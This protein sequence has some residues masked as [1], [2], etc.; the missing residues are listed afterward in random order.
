MLLFPFKRRTPFSALSPGLSLTLTLAS[1]TLASGTLALG[2]LPG[3]GGSDPTP[4]PSSEVTSTPETPTSVP[5][6][7]V[8]TAAPTPTEVPTATPI[9]YTPPEVADGYDFWIG[10]LG[11][12][13]PLFSGEQQYPF[14]CTTIESNLGQP[15]IDNVNGIGNAVFPEVNGVPDMEGT[16][17]GYSANCSLRTRVDYY[18]FSSTDSRFHAYDENNP[19]PDLATL[20]VK[21]KTE[22]FLVRVETGTLDRFIYTIAMLAP[23]AEV[24]TSPD[25]LDNSAWN[26]KLLY[27]FRGG[28]GIGHYQGFA[29]WAGGLSDDE[30][31]AFSQSLAKGYA[32]AT[33]TGN[34]TGVHYNMELAHEA[35]L[36]VKKHFVATYGAPL[37]TV[38]AGGS[39]GGVQQYLIGQNQDDGDDKVLDGGL[40]LY[41]YPDMV[42]QTIPV[43]DC[44]L[45]EQYFLE[46]MSRNPINSKWA[47]WSNRAWIEG[48]NASDTVDNSVFDTMGS[49]ECIEAWFF[50]EPLA[51]NPQVTLPEYYEAMATYKYPASAVSSIKWT[52]FND[53]QNIYSTDS[54]GFAAIPFDNEGVQYGLQALKDGNIT[55]DEFLQLNSCIGTWK[56]QKDYVMWNPE[57]DPFDANNMD[58]DPAA[59][60]NGEPSPRRSGDIDAMNAAYNRRQVFVGDIDIPLIDIRPYLEDELDMH[61][62]RESFAAR[63]RMLNFDGDAS[64]QVVWFTGPDDDFLARFNEGL[65]LMDTWLLGDAM[66]S[67]FV[68]K[69]FD[70]NGNVIAEGSGVWDGILNNKAPGACTQA[71]PLKSSPRMVAGGKIAGDVFKCVL[72]SVDQALSDGTF[73]TVTFTPTQ[74]TYLKKIFETGVCDYSKGDVGLP[75]PGR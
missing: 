69:C 47:K 10:E 31:T 44:N 75:G 9:P 48:M 27:Y 17:L 20:T 11:P 61:H 19:P 38:G 21:G 13:G 63:S 15:L 53:L 22:P 12:T 34:E 28:V 64:N 65:A 25:S 51:L 66:P 8:P 37:Y 73:G 14:V 2:T 74:K 40:P 45:L 4:T 5:L 36:M 57:S 18:Y 46:D 29:A 72:K 35:A 56:E 1:G 39:G 50:A 23:F 68:D 32:V 24:T 59:C 58:R 41:S 33:S 30:H 70:N 49:T 3:C 42:T 62:S 71:W 55:A 26:Q 7:P 43:G 16:P 60:L 54:R 6:T 52:H 67:G